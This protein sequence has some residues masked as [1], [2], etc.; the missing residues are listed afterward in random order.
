MGELAFA[1]HLIVGYHITC[2]YASANGLASLPLIPVEP[3]CTKVL[4]TVPDS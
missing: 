2:L 1:I 4:A 3:N